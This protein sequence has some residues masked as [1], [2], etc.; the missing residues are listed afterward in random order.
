[1]LPIL[2]YQDIMLNNNVEVLSKFLQNA[3]I[4]NPPWRVNFR[5]S[6]NKKEIENLSDG[7]LNRKKGNN[8]V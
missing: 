8:A 1:M 4:C 3:Q 5:M 2:F 6:N 7:N